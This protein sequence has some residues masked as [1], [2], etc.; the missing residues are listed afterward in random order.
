M[1]RCTEG[2]WPSEDPLQPL[3]AVERQGGLR[4]DDGWSESPLVS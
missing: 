2:V 3:E 1:V 4:P